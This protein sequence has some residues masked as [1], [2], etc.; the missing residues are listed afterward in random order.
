MIIGILL[1]ALALRLINLNQSLW[2]DEAVQAVVAKNSLAFAFE[3]LRGDFHPPLFHLLMHFW[4]RIFG[5]SEISLRMPSVLFGIGTVWVVYLLIKELT[6][7]KISG[8]VASLL[9]ATAPYHVY[10]SQEARMYS[11]VTFFT[12]LSMY[13]FLRVISDWQLAISGNKG[14]P[15]HSRLFP[16]TSHKSPATF[17]VFFTTLALYSD[18]YAVLVILA[19]MVAGV[20]ILRKRFLKMIFYYLAILILFA[21][22]LPLLISQLKTGTMA[23]MALPGWGEL[24]NLG[25]LKALPLTFVKFS[26]GRITIFDKRLY[27]LVILG[28]SGILGGLGGWGIMKGMKKKGARGE[29]YTVLLFWLMTPITIA[30]LASTIIPNYQ[31]FRLLLVLPA[32]YLLLTSGL[33]SIS[34]TVGRRIALIIILSINLF[35]LAVYYKNPYFWREDWRSVAGL[36]KENNLP[37]VISAQSF[38]WPLIYYR[39]ND[40][41]VS[42]SAGDGILTIDRIPSFLAKISLNKKLYYTPYLADL[43]DPERLVPT[44]IEKDGFVKIKEISFNQIPVW[45]YEK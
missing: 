21:P 38:N 26:I 8:P 33:T 24:V 45:E 22:V 41:I 7:S 30:W 9:L 10:Y 42:A 6:D 34:S 32:F 1:V 43:Y 23:T 17:Y 31:P 11:M 35:S 28:V 40:L 19:Q 29:F 44:W 39:A 14:L 13:Y 12:C 27:A 5:S 25:F 37:I 2:L 15:A 36:A 16:I 4:V 18:Y 3:E 20:I